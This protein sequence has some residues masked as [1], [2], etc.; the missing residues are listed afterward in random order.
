MTESVN[1]KDEFPYYWVC[2]SDPLTGCSYF[3]E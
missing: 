2:P 1:V 3:N